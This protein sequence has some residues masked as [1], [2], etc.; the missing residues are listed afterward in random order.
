MSLNFIDISSYQADLNLA[1]VFAQNP[2]DGV[3]VKSTEGTSYVNPFCDRFV[4]WLIQHDKPWG[5]YHFLNGSDPVTEAQ[6]FVKNT[7]NYFNDGVPVADFEAD[8]VA[9]Y[10][11]MYLRKFL[12]TVYEETGIKPIVY[13]N[14][15]T[16]QA[17]VDG[18]KPIAE[19]GYPLWLAQWAGNY[20]NFVPKP[21]QKGS[22]APFTKMAMQQYTDKGKLNGY[23]ANLDLDIFFGDVEE[24]NA[25]AGRE[26]E[27][28][29]PTPAPPD[30]TEQIKTAMEYFRQGMA[31]LERLI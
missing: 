14:L 24:W 25:L 12:E 9:R 3:I 30:N 5:F 19:N 18:F 7:I 31:I 2:L 27:A 22:F 15:S 21:W 28:P 29:V 26:G 1:A 4:Q 8:I 16:I 13:C 6:Y 23:N 17:D 20:T 10:G 11:T